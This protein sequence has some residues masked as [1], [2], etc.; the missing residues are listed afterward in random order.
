M[1]DLSSPPA[2]PARAH[3]SRAERPMLARV[4][5][6]VYWM[7]RYIERAEHVARALLVN[8]DL[9]TDVGDMAPQLRQR[10][11]QGVLQLTNLDATAPAPPSS[12]NGHG[13]S[14]NPDLAIPHRMTL[15]PANSNSILNCLTKAR[16]NA[17]S[18]RE[19]ISAEMWEHLNTLYWSLKA[20][21][22]AAR[23][24][25]SPGEMLRVV[26]NGSMLFQ[27][28]TDQTIPRG[29]PWLFTQVGKFLERTDV[30]ARLLET[31]YLLLHEV[32]NTLESALR[33]IHWMAVLRSCGSIEAYRRRYLGDLEPERVAGFILFEPGL[34][35]SIR[36]AVHH[37][38]QCAAR[39]REQAN[40]GLADGADRILGRLN[41]DLEFADSD[42]LLQRGLPAFLASIRAT[43]AQAHLAIQKAYFLN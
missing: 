30:T 12:G 3:A 27:G 26:I 33:N 43:T 18:V 38:K 2:A 15:D 6:A 5:D 13:H 20:D 14:I 36:Y 40:P 22:A 7:S 28:L 29:Q 39:I 23:F 42:N 24:E 17:R 4:A 1:T 41:A 31:K 32:E 9:L 10:L 25:E 21:D 16:E 19:N 35:R 11:W 34:P 8:A 37:A